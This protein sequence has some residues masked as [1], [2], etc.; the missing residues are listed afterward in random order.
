[1]TKTDFTAFKDEVAETEEKVNTILTE[2]VEKYKELN[3][4]ID[5]SAYPQH[6]TKTIVDNATMRIYR[7]ENDYKSYVTINATLV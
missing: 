4:E 3:I 7:K 1:M 2:F 6:D 5:V